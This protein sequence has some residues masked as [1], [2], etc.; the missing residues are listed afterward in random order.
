MTGQRWA[1]LEPDAA[2]VEALDSAGREATREAIRAEVERILGLPTETE[3][4][5]ERAV[6]RDMR[7]RWSERFA[8]ACATM[9]ASEIRRHPAVR[10]RYDVL[11]NEEGGGQETFTPLGYSKGKRIDVV[12]SGPLVG[13]QIGVS[14]KGLNFADDTSGNHD[15]NL[16]GRLYELR[17]EVSTVHDYLPRAFMGAIFFMPVAG[18]HD[19]ATAPSSFAHLVAELRART[20]RLDSSVAAHAWRC[21]FSAVCL[22]VPGDPSDAERGL[23]TGAARYFPSTVEEGDWNWPPQRGLP[24]L[25]A[26]VDRRQLVNRLVA[27]A[28]K[29]T[30]ASTRFALAEDEEVE[31]A[32][33]LEPDADTETYDIE[34]DEELDED[35]LETDDGE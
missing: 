30:A 25:D 28:I 13:L 29:G 10:R 17:D 7:K 9:I 33:E 2:I 14:L 15:K 20:G 1:D 23:R 31:E 18:C 24:R 5:R 19:K 3:R 6:L 4:R 32:S 26:T 35:A 12:V 11:P 16:T 34:E 22:Y 21:D 27:S 8:T